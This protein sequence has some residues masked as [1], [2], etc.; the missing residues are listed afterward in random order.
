MIGLLYKDFISTKGKMILGFTLLQLVII[1]GLHFIY[2]DNMEL[3][4]M[5]IYLLSASMVILFGVILFYLDVAL[6]KSD[7]QKQMDY[8]LSTPIDRSSYVKSKYIYV[9][10]AFV[11]VTVVMIIE[12][13]IIK[14]GLNSVDAEKL[15]NNLWNIF[16]VFLGVFMICSAIELPFYFGL[17]ASVGKAVKEGF[18][19]GLMFLCVAYLLFGDLD[20]IK[21]MNLSVLVKLIMKDE[22]SLKLLQILAPCVGCGVF[23]LSYLL[24]NILF[25]KKPRH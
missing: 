11:L 15:I 14:T 7:S 25:Q 12:M 2:M 22:K 18:W 21:N 9:L 16:P 6:V 23:V 1:S 8:F 3:E 5:I 10:S 17:G 20:I 4:I 13:L 19:I 24:S